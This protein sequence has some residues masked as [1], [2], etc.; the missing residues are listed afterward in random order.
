MNKTK[1]QLI[2]EAELLE[3]E[4]GRDLIH[5]RSN[6]AAYQLNADNRIKAA[7]K[8]LRAADL[9]AQAESDFCPTCGLSD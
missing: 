3:A 9:R 8:K 1:T 7:E 4:A 6:P 2:A 5:E